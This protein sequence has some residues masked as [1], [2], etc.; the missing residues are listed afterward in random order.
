MTDTKTAK[1]IRTARHLQS[2]AEFED[3]LDELDTNAQKLVEAIK[4]LRRDIQT[5]RRS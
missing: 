2:I 3:R 4:A 5:L 1:Q